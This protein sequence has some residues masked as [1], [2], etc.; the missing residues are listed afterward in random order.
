MN[1]PGFDELMYRI[2]ILEKEKSR[3]KFI[4]I[5]SLVLLALFFLGSVLLVGVIGLSQVRYARL[6]EAERDAAMRE[7]LRAVEAQ[8][9]AEEARQRAIQQRKQA[10]EQ[11]D[12]EGKQ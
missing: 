2:A 4:G 8:R 10:A 12:Q 7:Q 11:K 9:A 6:I 5:G 3:W 1:E